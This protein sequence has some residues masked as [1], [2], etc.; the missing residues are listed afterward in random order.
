MFTSAEAQELRAYYA[1]YPFDD[2][3]NTWLPHGLLM[4]KLHG[5][6]G[7]QEPK[8]AKDFMPFSQVAEEPEP[9]PETAPR[10]YTKKHLKRIQKYKGW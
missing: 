9:V 7:S 10:S 6:V 8:A 2:E 1:R 3:S 4:A 5:M